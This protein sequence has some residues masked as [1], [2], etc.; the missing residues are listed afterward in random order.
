VSPDLSLFGLGLGNTATI[1]LAI[2]A[3]PAL[4][5]VPIYTQALTPDALGNPFGWVLSDAAGGP[6]GN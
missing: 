5:C 6:I 1:N 2:P 4:V 3:D